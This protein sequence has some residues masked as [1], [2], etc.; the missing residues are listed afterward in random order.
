L[1]GTI[2]NT[3]AVVAAGSIGV[4]LG[5]RLPNRIRETV[6]AGIGLT[7]LLIGFQMALKTEQLLIVLGSVVLGGIVGEL[8]DLDRGLSRLGSWLEARVARL[9]LFG[10][11]P[12]G[13]QADG[14]TP[15]PSFTRGF[16][17]ASLVFC[18]GPMTI[19]GSIQDGLTGDYQTLAVKSMLDAFT[20]LAFASSLGVGVPFSGLTVLVYQGVL[21]L[22]AGWLK[23]ALSD[24]MVTEMTATGGLL[25]VGIGLQLLE[26]RRIRVA[27]LLPALAFAPL[28]V[29]LLG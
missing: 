28:A 15:A 27:N 16:V 4:V 24:A 8:I 12:S 7:T 1:T 14:A 5:N 25:I 18:V 23:G 6:M 26:I 11:V 13:S 21:T 20:S 2:L 3:V 9:G 19:I 10:V 22:A 17:T 29:A